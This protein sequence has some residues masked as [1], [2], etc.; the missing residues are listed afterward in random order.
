MAQ[1][2]AYL[3]KLNEQAR[4]DF[5]PFL[6]AGTAAISDLTGFDFS[7]MGLPDLPGTLQLPGLNALAGLKQPAGLDYP[8]L[9]DLPQFQAPKLTMPDVPDIAGVQYP[10]VPTKAELT[11]LPQF[12]PRFDPNDPLYQWEQEQVKK[13]VR[14]GSAFRGNLGSTASVRIEAE[15]LQEL[16]VREVG[17]QFDRAV[18]TYGL[19]Y[20]TAQDIIAGVVAKYGLDKNAVDTLVERMVTQY[21]LDATKAQTLYSA[22]YK[23]ASDEYQSTRGNV[24][25]RYGA[26]VDKTMAE[27]GAGVDEYGRKRQ[28]I[29][30]IQRVDAQG[31]VA[32]YESDYQ[33]GLDIYGAKAK[34]TGSDYNALLNLANIGRGAATSVQEPPGIGVGAIGQSGN[35][36]ANIYANIGAQKGQ[37]WAGLPG[38]GTNALAGYYYGKK[39]G[40]WGE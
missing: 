6:E 2:I 19:D 3:E 34:T 8:E 20:R 10:D 16:S 13:A 37:F 39:A 30:D 38:A 29:T 15:R 11:D 27:Y 14:E 12:D 5:A 18:Q 33:R 40:L 1:Q 25:A 7:A 21:G 28:D 23:G 31:K 32:A 22:A 26:D 36:L 4:T 9:G 17:R 35:A 24:L